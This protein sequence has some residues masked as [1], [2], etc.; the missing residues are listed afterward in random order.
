MEF[1]Y[2]CSKQ[3]DHIIVPN[4]LADFMWHSHM[5]DNAAYKEDMTKTLGKVLNH[6]DAYP[7]KEL[8]NYDKETQEFTDKLLPKNT[9]GTLK[10]AEE[11]PN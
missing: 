8:K 5:Q 10:K 1:L 3:P 4:M 2:V 9:T 11:S 7:D 6:N